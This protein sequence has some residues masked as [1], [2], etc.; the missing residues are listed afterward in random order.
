VDCL[1]ATRSG[2]DK[3]AWDAFERS[4]RTGSRAGVIMLQF[5][6]LAEAFF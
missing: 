5:V 6:L 2:D 1:A 4:I 3:R